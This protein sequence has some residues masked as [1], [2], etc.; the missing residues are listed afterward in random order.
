MR[1]VGIALAMLAL[2]AHAAACGEEEREPLPSPTSAFP[3][4]TTGATGATGG[5]GPT[6]ELPTSP[7]GSA[8]GNLTEGVVT[9]QLSGDVEVE[10]SL[11]ELITAVYSPPPGGLAVVWTAGGTDASTIGIG[12]SSFVGTRETSP[13]L[14]LTI[15]AQT[16]DGLAS[17]LSVGG[18]CSV[19]IDM[20]VDNELAG[21]FTCRDLTG[22]LGEVVDVSAS[23]AATG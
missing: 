9:F 16:D 12:G 10:R 14:S 15:A 17:F 2:S 1:T 19:T 18:E 11:R 5:T 3:T 22:S 4:E 6:A 21:S 13:M 23:F 20:A 8:T 7:P